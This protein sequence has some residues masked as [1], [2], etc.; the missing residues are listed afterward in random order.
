MSSK[1][2]YSES[3][4]KTLTTTSATANTVVIILEYK[5]YANHTEAESQTSHKQ[6]LSINVMCQTVTD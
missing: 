3:N 1:L 2:I 4:L 6:H 5:L